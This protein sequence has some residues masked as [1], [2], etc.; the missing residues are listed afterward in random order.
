[1]VSGIEPMGD[2]PKSSFHEEWSSGLRDQSCVMLLPYMTCGTRRL[3]SGG[4]Q[5]ILEAHYQDE[6]YMNCLKS[7]CNGTVSLVHF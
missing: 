2:T 4:S 7:T 5:Q 3:A 6:F 1:M